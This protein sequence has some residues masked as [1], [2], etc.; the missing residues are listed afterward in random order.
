MSFEYFRDAYTDGLYVW[1]KIKS[2]SNFWSLNL[3]QIYR[4]FYI[5]LMLSYKL[6]VNLPVQARFILQYV[7]MYELF[8]QTVHQD[9]QR[10]EADVVQCQINTVIQ[11]LGWTETTF[12]L[13]PTFYF[14]LSHLLTGCKQN[15]IQQVI[16]WHSLPLYLYTV[17]SLISRNKLL[18]YIWMHSLKLMRDCKIK[19]MKT[20]TNPQW[21]MRKWRD[22]E[23][24]ETY[25]L[26][27]QT[28]E[29]V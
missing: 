6:H 9:G 2:S 20:T 4:F 10:G 16:M 18:V 27:K 29:L 24:K 11:S 1:N 21:H 26:W 7:W 5:Q 23:I 13:T 25:L 8:K 19:K 28:E 12:H 15:H 14:K 3:W 17:Y 22:G